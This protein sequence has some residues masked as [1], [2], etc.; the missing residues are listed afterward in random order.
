ME[1]LFRIAILLSHYR[2]SRIDR[3]RKVLVR[4]LFPGCSMV[5]LQ[6]VFKLCKGVGPIEV[7]FFCS[8]IK[9]RD[10]FVNSKFNTIFAIILMDYDSIFVTSIIT[11]KLIK[12]GKVRIVVL[13]GLYNLI[14]WHLS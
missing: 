12:S 7:A 3:L 10:G 13:L 8:L 5:A 14:K 11:L 4:H 6:H 1:V 2:H 9:L